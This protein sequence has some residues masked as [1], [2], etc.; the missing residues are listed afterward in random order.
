LNAHMETEFFSRIIKKAHEI[1]IK[2]L[3]EIKYLGMIGVKEGYPGIEFL[4][5][6][7]RYDSDNR[8]CGTR[9]S[10]FLQG[11]VLFTVTAS[12]SRPKRRATSMMKRNTSLFG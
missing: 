1:G 2:V 5:K 3:I 4:T 12:V 10:P 11:K 6:Q 7:N 9:C 8:T